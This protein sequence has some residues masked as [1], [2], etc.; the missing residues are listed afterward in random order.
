MKHEWRK[1]EKALYIP[2][3]A[4]EMV[5]VPPYK[6][7][8]L[9]GQG[10]PND[11]AFGQYIEALYGASYTV[12]MSPKGGFAPPD[13]FEYSVYPL[14]GVWDITEQAKQN[15]DGRLDKDA[16]VYTLMIRQPDFVSEAFASEAL[17]R[18][19]AKKKNT[20]I[21]Q[22]QFETIHEGACVQMLHTGS[23]DTEPASFD[24]MEQFCQEEGLVR[25]SKRHR[26][27]YL[28][29]FRRTAADKLKTTLRFEVGSD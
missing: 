1:R 2:K 23:F 24:K 3:G 25:A 29:D 10:N 7:F 8:T 28:S 17:E 18:A 13:Y 9:S 6:Y 5:D 22:I 14:E 11:S 26:E 15:Y 20:L 4:P 27:I 12:R 19:L 21:A 16:L